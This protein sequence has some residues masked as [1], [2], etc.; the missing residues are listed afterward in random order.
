MAY[1][2]TG[3]GKTFTMGTAASARELAAAK[4]GSA[5]VAIGV[6]PRAVNE[7]FEY[8]KHAAEL[9]ETTLMVGGDFFLCI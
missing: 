5:S 2:Q 9:Y 6:V 1:G 7:V 8:L 3:S 4:G